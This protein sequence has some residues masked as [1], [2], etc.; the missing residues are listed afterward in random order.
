M[1]VQENSRLS[2]LAKLSFDPLEE[3]SN[4]TLAKK[5]IRRRKPNPKTTQPALPPKDKSVAI[6]KPFTVDNG[7]K[8]KDGKPPIIQGS[9][10]NILSNMEANEPTFLGP[11]S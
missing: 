11:D 1:P 9:L 6:A 5:T 7:Q 10:Y 8:S 3:F 2:A 4:W